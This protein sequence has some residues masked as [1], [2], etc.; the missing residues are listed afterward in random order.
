MNS[1]SFPFRHIIWDWNG[2]LLDDKWLCIK[3]INVLLA[4][5]NLP[6][7]DANRYHEIF[8][9]PV[10]TYY[11]K[12]GFDFRSEPYEVPA[13]Q[14][15]EQYD[16]G[17]YECTLQPEAL[18]ML[19]FFRDLG[20]RQYLL[21]A[22]ESE[23]LR[24][25]VHFHGIGHF[26]DRIKGLDNHLAHGKEELGIELMNEIRPEPGTTLMIGD[27]CHDEEV[28]RAMGIPCILYSGG[29]FP[30]WRLEA[31]SSRIVGKLADILLPDQD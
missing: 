4:A 19:N 31:C 23:V 11:E 15:I 17:K 14:F 9:F 24:D 25:M 26:F 6:E 8:G 13:H 10:R 21:S 30:Q 16:S 20:C 29:H 7:I 2:T 5:R 18:S 12:A 22:S 3:S 28:A 27:T 1:D